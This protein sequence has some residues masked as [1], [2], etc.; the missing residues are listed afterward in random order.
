MSGIFF[1]RAVAAHGVLSRVRGMPSPLGDQG[2]HAVVGNKVAA[3]GSTR[4]LKGLEWQ[5]DRRRCRKERGTAC[6]EHSHT[7]AVR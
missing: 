6:K 3:Q 1:T 7:I 5:S 4:E 2:Y